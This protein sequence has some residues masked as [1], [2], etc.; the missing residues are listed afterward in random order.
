M[1]DEAVCRWC[2]YAIRWEHGS[3]YGGQS[4]PE[5]WCELAPTQIGDNSRL[6]RPRP[7]PDLHD[8]A[9]VELWLAS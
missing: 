6:H 8:H 9:A 3:W 4:H 2:D 7:L 5:W 1:S